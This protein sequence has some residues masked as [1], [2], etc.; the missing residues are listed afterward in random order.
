M[1]AK[2]DKKVRSSIVRDS[3]DTFGTNA[4]N[5]ILTLVS[6]L[7]IL[8]KVNPGVKGLYNTVQLWGAG[9]STL[10]GL[11]IN[12]AVIY[13]VSR[14]KIQNTQVSIK[15]LAVGVSSAIILIGATVV[16]ALRG[17]SFFA[18]TPASYLAAI[19]VYGVG[20]FVL[21]IFTAIL[22]GENKFRSYNMILL[23][24][25]ILVTVLALIVFLH[26]SATVWVW[27]T[28]AITLSMIVFAF[29]CIKR[30]SGSMPQPNPGDDIPI[31]AG[32]IVKYS[33]KAHVSNVMTYLNQNVGSYIVQGSY[34]IR[35][36]GV[37]SVA[38]TMM[39]LV[40]IIPDAVS[41]VIMSR[42]AAMKEQS[43]KLR[44][45]LIST[46]IVTYVTLVSAVLL[47]WVANVFVPMI[48]P[49]Y[50]GALAPLK[51]LIVGS[52]FISYAKVLTNSISAYGRPE[53]NILPTALGIASNILLSILLI[54]VMGIN[55]VAMATSISMTIQGL[56]SIIIF[57]RFT[58]TPFYK[59]II[60]SGDE[61]SIVKGIM[62]R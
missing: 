25:K 33:L 13:F 43:D 26:P 28:I 12:S 51:Y 35:N 58:K 41:L 20:S 7:V 30:W 9:F 50:V 62:K 48:F 11:S 44:L 22:R 32:S 54:P 10:L 1:K 4:F 36:F 42:I 29:F 56:T 18:G 61:I 59:L 60:P 46:K 39:G 15:K 34:G 21:N 5:L 17:S 52:V 24:Q 19:V 37:Y 57:C 6:T 38:V 14:Y 31:Q 40:W 2:Q 3:L 45:T 55:G 8:N 23:V 47:V 16:F 49:M 27:A 53:L